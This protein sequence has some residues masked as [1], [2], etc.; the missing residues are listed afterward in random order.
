MKKTG[1]TLSFSSYTMS[2]HVDVTYIDK[3]KS[4]III[5]KSV[6]QGFPSA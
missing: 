2:D 3:Y 5:N 4:F 6:L 1:F